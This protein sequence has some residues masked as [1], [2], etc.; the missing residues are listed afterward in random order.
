MKICENNFI[1]GNLLCWKF[2]ISVN[3]LG[4][5]YVD[6]SNLV[7]RNTHEKHLLIQSYN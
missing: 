7:Y 6:C 3:S 4:S 1:V 5:S 2:V